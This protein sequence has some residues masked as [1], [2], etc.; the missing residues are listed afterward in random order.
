M[1][2]LNTKRGLGLSALLLASLGCGEN[3]NKIYPVRG[4]VLYKGQPAQGVRVT[5]H[6]E[7][8]DK[9]I[10][11]PHPFAET[12]EDGGFELKTLKP[13]DGKPGVGAP[14]GSY[15]VFL[16][17]PEDASAKTPNVKGK[18][19]KIKKDLGKD[20]LKGRYSDHAH[21]QLRAQ[22]EAKQNQLPPFEIN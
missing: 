10:D 17:W 1:G 20:F 4:Q 14:E 2:R 21:I 19:K 5:F 15:Y 13:S 18:R 16:Y 11:A 12:G 9:D 7:G 3:A 8:R 22:V 6:M